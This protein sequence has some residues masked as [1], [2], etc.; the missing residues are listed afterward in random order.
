MDAPVVAEHIDPQWTALDIV[1]YNVYHRTFEGFQDKVRGKPVTW[2]EIKA[3][4]QRELTERGKDTKE[5]WDIDSK[6]IRKKNFGATVRWVKREQEV[7]FPD[8]KPEQV[9]S[10]MHR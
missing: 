3:A 9:D 10:R 6:S 8:V 1:L 2:I 4:S 7:M 5:F